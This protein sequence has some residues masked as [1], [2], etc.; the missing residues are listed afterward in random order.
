[1]QGINRLS[2]N[3]FRGDLPLGMLNAIFE[4]IIGNV[5]RGGHSRLK[6]LIKSEVIGRS[7]FVILSFSLMF[8]PSRQGGQAKLTH[9]ITEQLGKQKLYS[10]SIV[11]LAA[12]RKTL[13]RP[14]CP[15]FDG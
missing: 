15:E 11:L 9:Q 13:D 1:M 7:T 12:S 14:N 4:T 8:L 3:I 6:N 5:E 2:I 10:S